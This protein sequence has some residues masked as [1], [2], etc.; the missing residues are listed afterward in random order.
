MSSS[1][2]DAVVI[3]YDINAK[4]NEVKAA[5]RQQGWMEGWSKNGRDYYLPN[6]TLWKQKTS[7]TAGMQELRQVCKALGVT[8][9]RAVAVA[10]SDFE[11][12]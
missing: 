3:S 6:T 11:G 1:L 5:L 9:E 10:G 7:T 2:V 12:Y 4:H 8:I